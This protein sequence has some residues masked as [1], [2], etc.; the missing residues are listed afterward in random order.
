MQAFHSEPN[1]R[2]RDEIAASTLRLLRQ[3]YGSKLSVM[4]VKDL[5]H[6]LRDIVE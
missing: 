6:K 5:F 3:H 2:K 1:T 4:D